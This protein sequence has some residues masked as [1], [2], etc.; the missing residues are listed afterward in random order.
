M[1]LFIPPSFFSNTDQPVASAVILRRVPSRDVT[2]TKSEATKLEPVPEVSQKA[3]AQ[4]AAAAQRL[5]S[6]PLM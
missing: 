2:N 1:Y 4:P 6:L 3:S 5:L